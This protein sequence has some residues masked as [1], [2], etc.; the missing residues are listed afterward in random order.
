MPKLRAHSISGRFECLGEVGDRCI[1]RKKLRT[2]R[3]GGLVNFYGTNEADT[4]IVRYGVIENAGS[5]NGALQVQTPHLIF[6]HNTIR[7]CLGR[8]IKVLG[9]TIEI[10]DCSILNNSGEGCGGG[11]VTQ[12]S[13]VT[14]RRCLIADNSA[15]DGGG[16]CSFN[17]SITFDPAHFLAT[18]ARFGPVQFSRTA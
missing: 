2:L 15:Q 7:N 14:F 12:Q 10:R 13:D 9:E 3:T 11:I 17:G 1:S 4:S 18:A 8:G 6:E 16:S 5:Y